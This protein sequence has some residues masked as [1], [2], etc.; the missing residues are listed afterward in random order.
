MNSHLNNNS[1]RENLSQID[2]LEYMPF[3][4]KE[5]FGKQIIHMVQANSKFI[6]HG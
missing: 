1:S 3:N 2:S 5:E 4:M 6:S